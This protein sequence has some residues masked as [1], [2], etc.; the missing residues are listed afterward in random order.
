MVRTV[1]SVDL[2]KPVKLQGHLQQIHT[3][4]HPEIPPVAT[5]AQNETFRVE[6]FDYLGKFWQHFSIFEILVDRNP[7][8]LKIVNS[9]FFV[10]TSSEV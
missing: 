9:L 10:F 7:C 4:W 5:V 8:S 1:V 3:R 2:S 6:C